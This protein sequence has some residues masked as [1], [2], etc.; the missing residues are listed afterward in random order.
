MELRELTYTII[1]CCFAVHKNLG[2]GLL[3]SCYH[4]GLYYELQHASLAVRYNVPYAVSH[5]GYTVGE[6]FAD[7]VVENRVIIEVKAVSGFNPA[8]TAQLLNYLSISSCPVG[9]LVNFQGVSLEWRRLAKG[10]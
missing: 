4:N 6:Y 7:L 3:E 10:G 8:H 1:G 9:L 5:R 2:P